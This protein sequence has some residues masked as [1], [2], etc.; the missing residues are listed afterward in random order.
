MAP[1]DLVADLTR[2]GLYEMLRL[3]LIR[4]VVVTLPAAG[5]EWVATV[6]AGVSW[7]LLEIHERFVASAVVVSR[8]L[9]VQVRDPD[10]LVWADFP[11][12]TAVT[13]SQN[14]PLTWAAGQGVS[15]TNGGNTAPLPAPPYVAAA[16]SQVRSQTSLIDVGDQYSEVFLTVREWSPQ[17]VAT[18]AVWLSRQLPT[19]VLIDEGS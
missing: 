4:Q 5:A 14:I 1:R 9:R 2:Q 7:E 6:P 8:L 12:S 15:F 10:Q 19:T 16:G 11:S 17:Q 3:R 13:A 18:Q